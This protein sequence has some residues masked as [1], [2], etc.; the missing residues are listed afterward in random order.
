MKSHSNIFFLSGFISLFLLLFFF[1]QISK[2]N[3]HI[4]MSDMY[5]Y[6]FLLVFIFICS[7][8]RFQ[9]HFR[10]SIKTLKQKSLA[11]KHTF[12]S[13]GTQVLTQCPSCHLSA[14]HKKLFIDYQ[15]IQVYPVLSV[16]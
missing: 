1:I 16:I 11:H 3:I 2:Y 7:I 8:A 13:F 10:F 15:D 9:F 5:V 14:R 12:K 4:C 6:M